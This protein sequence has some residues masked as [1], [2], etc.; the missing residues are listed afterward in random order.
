MDS[1]AHT[2]TEYR[3][4]DGRTFCFGTVPLV[5]LN[6]AEFSGGKIPRCHESKYLG[7]SVTYELDWSQSSRS[8]SVCFSHQTMM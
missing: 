8:L 4:T 1:S 7:M 3:G 5:K 6:P 2:K